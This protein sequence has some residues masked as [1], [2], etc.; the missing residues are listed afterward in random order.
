MKCPGF[1]QV[2]SQHHLGEIVPETSVYGGP[3]AEMSISISQ[4]IFLPYR[5]ELL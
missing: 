1:V 4:V 2:P 3:I 5:F